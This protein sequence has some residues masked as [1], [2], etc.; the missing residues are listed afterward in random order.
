MEAGVP[1]TAPGLPHPQE[2][3]GF[4]V[5]LSLAQQLQDPIML[6]SMGWTPPRA[7]QVKEQEFSEGAHLQGA[8]GTVHSA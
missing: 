7:L 6:R 4:I 8:E 5:S 3:T 2:H 1:R